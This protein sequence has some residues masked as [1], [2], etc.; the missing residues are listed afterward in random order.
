MKPNAA[1]SD[2]QAQKDWRKTT[3][4]LF[5]IQLLWFSRQQQLKKIVENVY[6]LPV[7]QKS[8]QFSRLINKIWKLSS[9]ENKHLDY[10][11]NLWYINSVVNELLIELEIDY[12]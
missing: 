1:C 6:K 7:S 5:Q 3:L 11:S 2:S 12:F 10:K 4:N 9:Y 8:E